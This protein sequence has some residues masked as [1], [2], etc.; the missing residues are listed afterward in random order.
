MM[1]DAAKD[2]EQQTLDNKPKTQIKGLQP[3]A[4]NNCKHFFLYVDIINEC[5]AQTF[6]TILL[7]IVLS[8][9]FALSLQTVIFF[10][11]IFNKI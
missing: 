10:S 8:I 7:V 11:I 2:L 6:F 4:L 1:L 3:V 9:L 5:F